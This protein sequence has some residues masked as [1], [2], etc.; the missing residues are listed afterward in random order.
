VWYDAGGDVDDGTR[1]VYRV[2]RDGVPLSA[3]EA[4]DAW[5]AGQLDGVRLAGRGAHRF[6]LEKRLALLDRLCIVTRNDQMTSPHPGELEHGIVAYHYDG[7]LWWRDPTSP[8]L[9]Y[10]SRSSGRRG[11]FAWTPDRT[12]I[13]LQRTARAGALGVLLETSMPNMSRD[14]IL[15]PAHHPGA[16]HVAAGGDQR[17]HT[18]PHGATFEVRTDDASWREAAAGFAWTLHAGTNRLGARAVNAFGI[19]GPECSVTVE[20]EGGE[21]P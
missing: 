13:H 16:I 5:R 18:H 4:R 8:P 17:P 14:E 20:Y 1:A 19:T 11:D 6:V 10:V 2:E 15:G 7:Y 12:R 21:A 3:L 9:P